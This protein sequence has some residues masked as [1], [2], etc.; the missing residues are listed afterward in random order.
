MKAYHQLGQIQTFKLPYPSMSFSQ[1]I[2]PELVVRLCVAGDGAAGVG[3]P[4]LHRLR[5]PPLAGDP[6]QPQAAHRAVAPPS[7][8]LSK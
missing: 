6:A 8:G 2:T 1:V 7:P 4:G 5:P 3:W